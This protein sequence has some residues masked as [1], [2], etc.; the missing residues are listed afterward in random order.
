MWWTPCDSI[1]PLENSKRTENFVERSY[2]EEGNEWLLWIKFCKVHCPILLYE[3]WYLRILLHWTD[4]GVLNG[5]NFC[6]TLK[7]VLFYF[8]VGV[9]EGN[10]RGCP[11]QLFFSMHQMFAIVTTL[12]G[13]K[14]CHICRHYTVYNLWDL[15]R[16]YVE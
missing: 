5:M 8:P 2:T 1:K 15:Y 14:H 7:I 13:H 4:T 10:G 11:L 3:S 12:R 6:L 9:L 16:S